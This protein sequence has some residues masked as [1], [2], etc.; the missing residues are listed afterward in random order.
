[1]V[2][3][4]VLVAVDQDQDLFDLVLALVGLDH[5]LV[6][7]EDGVQVQHL[8]LVS[9]DVLEQDHRHHLQLLQSSPDVALHVP[10]RLEQEPDHEHLDE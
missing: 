7:P 8:F 4:V 5:D 9:V 1:M 10:L 3:V 6:D 2:L